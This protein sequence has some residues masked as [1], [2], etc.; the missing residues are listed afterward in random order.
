MKNVVVTKGSFICDIT[1]IGMRGVHIWGM[2]KGGVYGHVKSHF[3]YNLCVGSYI[4]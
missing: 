1:H 3:F 2:K 4:H